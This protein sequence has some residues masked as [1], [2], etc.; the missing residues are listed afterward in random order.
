MLPYIQTLFM[1]IYILFSLGSLLFP[2][3]G[4]KLRGQERCLEQCSKRNANHIQKTV[5]GKLNLR[6]HVLRTNSTFSSSM[7]IHSALKVIAYCFN[8]DEMVLCK[9]SPSSALFC[10]LLHPWRYW[11]FTRLSD[12]YQ[13]KCGDVACAEAHA[14]MHKP[15]Q[16]NVLCVLHGLFWLKEYYKEENDICI[17]SCALY[18]S[19]HWI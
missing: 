4:P 17:Y 6:R 19:G 12:E 14:C 1:D 18:L 15:R 16:S 3:M 13:Y 11:S 10:P 8:K 2:G 9:N 7:L 5:T